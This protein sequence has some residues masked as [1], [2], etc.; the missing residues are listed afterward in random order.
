HTSAGAFSLADPDDFANVAH[1]AIAMVAT[2]AQ[3][4][5]RRIHGECVSLGSPAIR[6]EDARVIED[7]V[8]H[9]REAPGT[10]PRETPPRPALS[11][12]RDVPRAP[13]ARRAESYPKSSSASR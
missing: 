1:P 9:P 10:T 13:G 12:R 11:P 2:L 6:L 8:R 5:S 4:R 3:K 7:C